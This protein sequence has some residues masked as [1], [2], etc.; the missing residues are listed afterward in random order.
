[1][2]SNRKGNYPQLCVHQLVE[3]QAAKTPNAIAVVFED[4]QI[5]YKELN[6]KADKL[7]GYLVNLGVVPETKIGICL[8]RSLAMVIGLL[9]ILKAGGAYV[10]IDPGY[11]T[12]RI[13]FVL[14]DAA[15]TVLV[16]QA[17]LKSELPPTETV[18]CIDSD[19]ENIANS[20]TTDLVEV[21]PDHLAYVI[22][23][24]GSTGKPKGVLIPHRNGVNLLNSVRHQPGLSAED[25]LLAVTT[26]SF[27][28]AFSEIFLPLSTGAKLVVVSQQVAADGMQLLQTLNTSGAT[29]MQ[30]TPITWRLL[31]EAGWG[32]SPNLK[33]ISTGEA[34][35]R[36]LADRLLPMG[37]QLWNLYGPT[38]ITIW[39]TGCQ[40]TQGDHNINIGHP[41]A[42]TQA[43]ILDANLQPLPIGVPGELHIGG[44]GVAR[45]YLNRPELTQE[46]FIANPFS[47]D[48]Q[49]RLYKTGDLAR[50]LPDG[51]I[52]CLGRIDYQVKVRGFRIE[53]GEIE[54]VMAQ[55]P[56]V[57][58]AIAIARE[59]NPGERLLAGYFV[60]NTDDDVADLI[61]QLR[62]FLK[63][64]LPDYMVPTQFMVLDAMPLTPNGKVDRRGLP[65]PD[66]YRADL[67][68]NYVAP[69]N[70]IEMQIAE[71]WAEV[72]GLE[73]VGIYDNFFE[74]GGYSLLAIQI[75]S[76]LRQSLQIEILLPSLF[77]LPTVADLS[78]RVSA[79]LWATESQSSGEELE[80]DY[81]EGEL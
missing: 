66:N 68:A 50:F 22:Y 18:I 57:K 51:Q 32:G 37:A 26:I 54:A 47:S 12:E 40:V 1:M 77:E 59:D 46:K 3:A 16:T 17:A 5:T 21:K 27:D 11:P 35:P 41:I 14:E 29:F 44:V 28:I 24:S 48:T 34:L 39:A 81:E 63:E 33:M 67:A 65:K 60:A 52:E 9:G 75:V 62:L 56:A 36:E 74:L 25:V 7:A 15:V 58:E 80:E 42:N 38:E 19:W 20:Q 71:I 73:K 2:E 31:L 78:T 64:R 13:S 23:T 79:L 45:G 4:R 53:L 61:P 8:E 69:R 30:P 49:S 70:D 43:Y 55:H 72:L 6:A 10:P 76:R